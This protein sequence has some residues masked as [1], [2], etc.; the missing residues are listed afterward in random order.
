MIVAG[1]VLCGLLGL[2][3]GVFLNRAI[4]HW[5]K[6]GA[7]AR[8]VVVDILTASLFA[9]TVFRF[10][11]FDDAAIPAYLVFFASLVA[12]SV[13]DFDLRII[14]NRIVYPTIFAAIPLLALAAAINGDFEPLKNA[15]L[16]GVFAFAALFVIHLI[17]P[18]GMGFGDVR[19]SFILGLFLGWLSLQHVL[20]GI[21]LGFLLGAFIGLALVVTRLRS[22]KDAIPFGPFL[23][24]GAA[25]AV[26]VGSPLIDWW[27]HS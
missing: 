13:I 26:F 1:A 21:F 9:A 12:V 2:G 7:L 11:D 15:L 4:D 17:S 6:S 25:L 3:V 23:A 5:C 19:L 24:G 22:R 16:G 27:L 10:G 20:V 14:P 8:Y 18:A